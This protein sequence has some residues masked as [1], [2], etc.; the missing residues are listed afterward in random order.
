MV[1][2]L[3]A[4]VEEP[5]VQRVHGVAH[6]EVGI[7]VNPAR[8]RVVGGNDLAMLGGCFGVHVEPSAATAGGLNRHP[9]ALRGGSDR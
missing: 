7:F 6:R 8:I 5:T 9:A 2:Q 3:L 4:L 1:E